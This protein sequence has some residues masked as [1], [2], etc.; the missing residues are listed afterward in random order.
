M[1]L[2]LSRRLTLTRGA[3]QRSQGNRRSNCSKVAIPALV[4]VTVTGLVE[5]SVAGMSAP[6]AMAVR[7]HENQIEIVAGPIG[8]NVVHING[9]LCGSA[10]AFDRT[11]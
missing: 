9:S 8:G 5:P 10:C 7:P 11:S 3:G 1:G 4:T 2:F 6:V